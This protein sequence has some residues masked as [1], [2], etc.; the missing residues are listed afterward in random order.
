MQPSAETEAEAEIHTEEQTEEEADE[1]ETAI[2]DNVSTG[3]RGTLKVN[4][5]ALTVVNLVIWHVHVKLNI[6]TT[7]LMSD[8]VRAEKGAAVEREVKVHHLCEIEG[9]AHLTTMGKVQKGKATERIQHKYD[10]L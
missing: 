8:S 9:P 1:E 2:H 6:L 4:P 3:I 7:D 10:H 5:N